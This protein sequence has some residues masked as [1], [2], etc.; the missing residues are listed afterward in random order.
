MSSNGKLK[1]KITSECK[2]VG[3]IASK[4]LE[5]FEDKGA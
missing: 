5:I 3:N 1:T 4:K 2:L